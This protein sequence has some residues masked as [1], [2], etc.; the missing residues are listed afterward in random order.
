MGRLRLVLPDRAIRCV[1]ALSVAVFSFVAVA[2]E[3]PAAT[4]RLRPVADAYV[5]KSTPR[6]NYGKARTLAADARPVTR[7]YLRFNLRLLGAPVVRATLRLYTKSR[8]A[9]GFA[10]RGVARNRWRERRI[11]FRTA[12]TPRRATIASSGGFRRRV[13]TGVD[14]TRFV[15]GKRVVSFAITTSARRPTILLA[16]RESRFSPRLEVETES[17]ADVQARVIAAGSIAGCKTKGDEATA[18][19]VAGL[20]GRVAT[21]GNHAYP[22]GT[23]AEFAN[24]YGP[25]WGRFRE[26]TSP[27]LGLREYLTPGATGYFGYFRSVLAPYGPTATDP[28]KGYYSYDLGSWH[29]VVLN[30]KCGVAGCRPGSPQLEWLR[31]DLAAHRASCTLAY[32]HRARF[33]SRDPGNAFLEPI[34]QVL[35]ENGVELVLAGHGRQYE[36]FAPQTPAG[37]ADPAR[38]IRQFIVGT[39]GVAVRPTGIPTGNSEIRNGD[40]LGVLQLT[41]RT[42]RYEWRFVPVAGKTFSDAGSQACH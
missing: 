34:W 30:T 24:C 3:A 25:S 33:S 13:W 4:K 17:S 8:S 42:T 27:A 39:G 29:V 16:S 1:V 9:R 15:R 26:R 40:T 7:A 36:R 2:G 31:A 32:A 19:L 10:V 37:V 18:A 41:L 23:P 28:K 5:K 35:Y 11:T 14:V 38:G 21:L 20:P 22:A 6:R 12:P